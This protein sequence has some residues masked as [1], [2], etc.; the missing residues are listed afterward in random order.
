[1]ENNIINKEKHHRIIDDFCLIDNKLIQNNKLPR[2]NPRISPHSR[3]TLNGLL[4]WQ[5]YRFKNLNRKKSER[6]NDIINF[7]KCPHVW[8]RHR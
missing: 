4:F 8:Q 3:A 5:I 1:M 6:D 7:Y 2:C